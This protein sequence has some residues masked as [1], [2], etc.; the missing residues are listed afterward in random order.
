MKNHIT[1]QAL[2]HQDVVQLHQW[3]QEE[4]VRAFWEDGHRTLAQ[5]EQYY[6]PQKDVQRYLFSIDNQAVGLIQNYLIGDQHEYHAFALPGKETMGVDIFIG[7]CNYLGKGFALPVLAE[8]IKLHC[9][10]ERIIVD[11]NPAN[12]KAIQVYERYGF[13][14]INDE[15]N[16]YAI[17]LRRAVRALVYNKNNEILLIHAV[18]GPTQDKRRHKTQA[19]WFTLGGKI[20]INETLEDA[21]QRELKEEAGIN[22]YQSQKIAFGE[23]VLLWHDFPTRVIETYFAVQAQDILLHENNL[24][25]E[26]NQFI[27]DF[28]WWKVEDL[29]HS[30]EIIYPQCLPL[31][32]QDFFASKD[33]HWS[34]KE[35]DL[36]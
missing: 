19:F 18:G 22:H 7:E 15:K 24:T 25:H 17:N 26:E 21:L 12:A 5:V 23:M 29:I 16:I 30:E 9:F 2:T 33:K 1:F 14:K 13:V 32:L 11:P 35:I 34:I 10:A 8:F 27:K 6:R 31:L 4:H 28:K 20:E 36:S 3:L